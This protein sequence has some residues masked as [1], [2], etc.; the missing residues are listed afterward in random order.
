MIP[1]RRKVLFVVSL[2]LLFYGVGTVTACREVFPF[3]VVRDATAAARA[4]LDVYTDD[5]RLIDHE[6]SGPTVRRQ[7]PDDDGQLFLVAGGPDYH[8]AQS[9]SGQMLAWI[10]DR[11]GK[12][13]HV[14]EFN[15]D[16]WSHLEHVHAAPLKWNVYPVGLHLYEDG[17]LL[18][19]FQGENCWP[20]GIGLAKF[21]RDSHLLWKRELVT[22]HWFSVAEDGRI[23]AAAM[24]ILDSPV[25]L[26]GSN[27]EIVA[28]DGRITQDV[29]IVLDPDGNL[30][31]EIPMLDA[32][33]DSGWIGLFQGASDDN[34]NA[35]T[36][37][38]THLNDVRVVS[39]EAAARNPLLNAGDILVSFR[40]LN[41]VGILDPTTKRFKWMSSGA[42]IRQHSPR[43]VGDSILLLDNR[44]GPRLT[45]GARLVSIPLESRLPTTVFPQT[46]LGELP[47][48]FCTDVAGYLDL[49]SPDRVLV[50]LTTRAEIWEVNLATGNVEWQYV[51][52]DPETRE[53]PSLY[54]AQ[55]V[56]DVHFEFNRQG[57]AP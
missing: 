26:G 44:G 27:A 38:P 4:Y 20:Y 53:R 42:A 56:H 39:E 14:W 7:L 5:G 2:C 3:T 10:M 55:Y 8:S 23:Y 36:G 15:R 30:L 37:D 6:L 49:R 17:S 29:V 16:I 28:A 32:L 46:P 25:P 41:A 11:S 1:H 19:G 57:T 34:I 18:V 9:S 50:T 51:Y 21:D 54:T 40:S 12:I 31:D 22:H 35:Y 45:G 47:Q 24:R 13:Q 33:I 48:P 43:L 52:V